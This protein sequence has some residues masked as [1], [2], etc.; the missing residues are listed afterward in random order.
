[1]P[2]THL[3]FS[4]ACR[5]LLWISLFGSVSAVQG[6]DLYD[7]GNSKLFAAYLMQSRQFD[8]AAYE[9]DRLVFMKPEND[10]LRSGLLRALRLGGHSDIGLSRWNEWQVQGLPQSRVLQL[11]YAKI[12]ILQAKYPILYEFLRK[13][14]T[15]DSLT[16]ARLHLYGLLLEQSWPEAQ[17]QLKTWPASGK[18]TRRAEF[19]SLIAHGNSLKLKKSGTAALLSVAVPGLGKAYAG[20]WK[21]GLISLVFVGLN[22]WQAYRRFDQEGTDTFWGWVHG[23]LGLGFYIG[24]VYGSH[25]AARMYNKRK[26]VHLSDETKHLVFPALD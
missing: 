26:R 21:D 24:N 3:L 5:M 7:F 16:S 9:F 14:N 20:Q 6:Q 13:P 15:L 1:M 19:E 22:A 8:Q 10:T 17:Q 18:L 4:H 2:K 23:G 25:K 11:E 12:L